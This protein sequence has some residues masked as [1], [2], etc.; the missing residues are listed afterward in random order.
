MEQQI[1][2]VIHYCWFGRNKKPL[3][4]EKCIASWKKYCPDYEILEWNEDNYDITKNTYMNQAYQNQKWAFVSDYARL[5]IVYN[6]GGIYL[7]SDVELIKNLDRFRKNKAFIGFHTPNQVNTGCVLGAVPKFELIKELRDRYNTRSFINEDGTLNLR[8]C[9]DYESEF[10]V[11]MGLKPNNTM[12]VMQGMKIYPTEYFAPKAPGSG[13][14]KTTGKTV[15][16]H[17][18]NASWYPDEKVGKRE[19]DRRIFALLGEENGNKLIKFVD[20]ENIIKTI[21]SVVKEMKELKRKIVRSEVKW[22]EQTSDLKVKPIAFYLPQFHEIPENN[23]WWGEGF[24][25]WVNVKKAK[26]IFNGHYQ[27]RVPLDDNY[28]DLSDKKVMEYQMELAAKSGIYGFCFYHYWFNGKKML[29]KPVEQIIENKKAKLPFCLAWANEPWTKT[30]HGPGG[31]KEV[32]IRQ[33]YGEQN[34]WDKHYQYLS[35]FFEDKRYIKKDNKPL[36]LI[37][38][39]NEMKKYHQMFQRWNQLAKEQGFDGVYIVSMTAWKER[40]AKSKYISAKTDFVPGKWLRNQ[41]YS[42]E[43]QIR[44]YFYE[45]YPNINFWNR[46]MCSH[47]SYDKINQ[48]FLNQEHKK[49]EFR[50][51]FVDFDDSPRR[52]KNSTIFIGSTPKKFEKYLKENIK[53][54]QQEENEFLFINAWNEWGEG[55]YL[56]PDKKYGY[57]YLNAVKR[58]TRKTNN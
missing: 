26:P 4:V 18:Y 10:F 34:D 40:Q 49:N 17:H 5:D 35:T 55:N 44:K 39:I 6:N 25:E 47:Y 3:I 38:R 27:P 57:A 2:K 11:E 9:N 29:E 22:K 42:M 1:P 31:E 41:D 16:I 53:K 50:C 58:A 24:T 7:D 46:V 23:Q 54:S 21:N 28:Y 51:S 36:L 52:G 8:T 56:E 33:Q 19:R 20:S 15:S 37:Y 30:W 32:L 14:C 48:K 12:Q 45:K 13:I 43:K